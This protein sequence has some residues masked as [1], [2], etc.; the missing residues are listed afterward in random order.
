MSTERI[1]D[2]NELHPLVKEQAILL[3]DK[4]KQQGLNAKII[5]TYRS[6]ERQNYLYEQGRSRP[7]QIVTWTKS[8]NHT[9]R[10]AFDVIQN[11]KGD[12]YNSAFLTKVGKLAKEFGLDWGGTWSTPDKPHFENQKLNPIPEVSK[13]VEKP[14]EQ[15]VS[16][17]AKVSWNECKELGFLDGTRPLDNVTREEL[18]CVI[19]RVIKHL[20]K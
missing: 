9:A 12:E 14:K 1:S 13:P 11:V 2:L 7:G 20:N 16:E 5:E 15:V 6:Q 10:K 19:C 4:C 8:S 3:M 17:W 18:A